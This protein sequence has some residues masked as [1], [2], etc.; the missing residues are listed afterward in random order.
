LVR[1][2]LLYRSK[3][4]DCSAGVVPNSHPNFDLL[5]DNVIAGPSGWLGRRF[6][7][8]GGPGA[9]MASARLPLRLLR[10]QRVHEL[11]PRRV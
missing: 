2:V 8:P 6:R 10:R 11:R 1:A 9:W 7:V 3:F 5:W 4:S